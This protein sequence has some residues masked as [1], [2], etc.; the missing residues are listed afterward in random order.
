MLSDK[1]PNKGWQAVEVRR[2][3]V[4]SHEAELEDLKY[5]VMTG[6]ED[7]MMVPSKLEMKLSARMVP[8]MSQNREVEIP[9]R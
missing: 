1:L 7:A 3:A 9:P 6:C 5:E 8:K 2:K 4:D